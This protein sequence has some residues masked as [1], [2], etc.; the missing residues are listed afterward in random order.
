[1]GCLAGEHVKTVKSVPR[2][3]NRPWRA[4]GNPASE[5]DRNSIRNLPM[6]TSIVVAVAAV[7]VA[8]AGGGYYVLEVLPK[9]QLRAGLDQALAALPPGTTATYK[10]AT[11]SPVSRQAVVT[12]VTLHGELSGDPPLPFDV[13][14]DS[15][16]TTNAN[17]DLTNSWAKAAANP[18]ALSPDTALAVAD[19]IVLKGVTIHSAAIN[20][21]EDSARITKASVYPWALLHE[22]MPAWKDIRA[23][24][25]TRSQAP[26]MADL[27]PILRAEAAVMLAFAYDTYDVGPTKGT[28]T[29][30][31][32]D[33]AFDVNKMTG[34]GFDRGVMRGGTAEGITVKGARFGAV[35]IDRVAMGASDA[36]EP[37]TRIVNGEPLSSTMLNGM[38]FGRYEYNGITVQPPGMA[39]THV[40]AF[41]VGP[42]SFA[43]GVPVSG[44]FAWTDI[45]IAKS[46][47][48]NAQ[49]R[50]VFDRLGL[51]TMTVSFALAY[52][53]DV[54]G[55]HGTVH[56][57]M[58][59]V[60]ELGTV[61]LAAE[62]TNLMPNV[63]AIGTARLAHAK[64]RFDDA[65]LVDRLLRMGASKTGA[66][67]AVYRAQ[68]AEM[69]RQQSTAIGG[70]SPVILAAGQSAAD[71]VNSPHSLTI[72][73]SPPAPV[74]FLAVQR[75][76]ADP[77]GFAALVGL[78]VSANQP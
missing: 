65:S 23:S 68:I 52:N 49:A 19:A 73:L 71:F 1:L 20:V 36:R 41:S 9:Q 43:Q 39:A 24:L 72:E 57:T 60:N 26:A 35:S 59:K 42:V 64:L 15:V 22:G 14:I 37:L 47:M 21:T 50:D 8:A 27:Q 78:T 75:A 58:L 63:G 5:V 16:E 38:K 46:Q 62:V 31:G 4:G 25:A 69:A 3:P 44:E 61:T 56:D 70:G 53:W 67:P 66:D 30:P 11:Y 76:A 6:R 45:S 2:Q 74:P 13:T 34:S 10:D 7:L 33:I 17:L 28:E 77:G 32:I 29:L 48:P 18:A 40:G 12:G 55:Q 51:D 54:A